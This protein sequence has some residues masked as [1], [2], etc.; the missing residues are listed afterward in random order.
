MTGRRLN[1]DGMLDHEEVILV[2][3]SPACIILELV[4][5]MDTDEFVATVSV[6]VRHGN[7]LLQKYQLNASWS[8]KRKK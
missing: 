7:M 8:D 4:I 6:C 3:S 5:V 2:I 1:Y